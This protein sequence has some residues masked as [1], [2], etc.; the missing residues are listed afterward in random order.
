MA[1]VRTQAGGVR[2]GAAVGGRGAT[3]DWLTPPEIVKAL[4]PF[5]LDPCSPEIRPWDTA[6]KHYTRADGGLTQPWHGMVWMNPPYSNI[7]AW[8][9]KLADHGTGIALVF[10]RTETAAFHEH[11]WPRASA[12]LFLRGRIRF[13]RV[14]GE[15]IGR[16]GGGAG[17][18]APSVLIGYG[19]EAASR[20]RTCGLDGYLAVT[21]TGSKPS[22]GDA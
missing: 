4:G 19:T 2:F 20:L 13:H 7:R 5:D 21:D 10:A 16:T 3:D 1:D 8:L 14:D 17:A 9:A 18:G 11:V 6:A 15:A 22:G 12:L